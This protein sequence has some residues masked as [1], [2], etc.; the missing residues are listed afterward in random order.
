MFE[1]EEPLASGTT[2]FRAGESAATGAWA[3]DLIFHAHVAHFW[4]YNDEAVVIVALNDSLAAALALSA[5]LPIVCIGRA[6]KTL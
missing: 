2:R 6:T 5:V 4:S 1:L 3:C